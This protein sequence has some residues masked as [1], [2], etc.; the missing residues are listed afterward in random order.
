LY[1]EFEEL[2]NQGNE[3]DLELFLRDNLK[4]FP[5]K[6]QNKITVVLLK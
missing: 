6:V 1:K 5:E 4:K 2:L 3:K